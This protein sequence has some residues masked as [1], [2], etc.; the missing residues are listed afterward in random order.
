MSSRTRRTCRRRWMQ[1]RRVISRA[2]SSTTGATIEI[3]IL[4]GGSRRMRMIVRGRVKVL[5]EEIR[6]ALGRLANDALG[7]RA[8]A[9][10]RIALILRLV[11]I[12]P[13]RR[14]CSTRCCN[15]RRPVIARAVNQPRRVCT[16]HAATIV[17]QE[18]I[19]SSVVVRL[20][21][22]RVLRFEKLRRCA[23]CSRRW[24]TARR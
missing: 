2:A 8:A 21:T 15:R 14:R 9:L 23:R 24:P 18:A 6:A 1:I 5:R 7:F 19:S 13:S 10:A 11:F 16:Q 22:E 12:R 17:V 3:E 4:D 20:F